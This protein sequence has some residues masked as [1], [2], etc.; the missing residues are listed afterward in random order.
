MLY[1]AELLVQKHNDA[2]K[3]HQPTQTQAALIQNQALWRQDTSCEK[4]RRGRDSNP[5]HRFRQ[6][7]RLA[8]EHHRPLGHLSVQTAQPMSCHPSAP[9]SQTAYLRLT[10]RSSV[11]RCCGGPAVPFVAQKPGTQHPQPAEEEGFEPPALSRCGFQDRC[12]RPLGHSS[13]RRLATI[14][15]GVFC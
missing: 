9:A 5:R 2:E 14:T 4:Q 13:K 8:S 15:A 11:V 7:T 6:C 1:P 3:P 12:L 10:S